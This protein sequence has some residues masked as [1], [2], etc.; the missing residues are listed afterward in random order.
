MK[1]IKRAAFIFVVIVLSLGMVL[2]L[3]LSIL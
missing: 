2:P 3:I 1:G